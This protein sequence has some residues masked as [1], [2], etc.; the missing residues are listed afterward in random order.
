MTSWLPVN[1]NWLLDLAQC[2][3]S[4]VLQNQ[5]Q[6]SSLSIQDTPKARDLNRAGILGRVPMYLEV[7]QSSYW[8]GPLAWHPWTVES[9]T[10]KGGTTC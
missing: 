3:Q 9:M 2:L 7:E 5:E 8:V 6:F 1:S 4:L 10:A